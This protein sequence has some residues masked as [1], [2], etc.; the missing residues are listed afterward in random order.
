V[1]LVGVDDDDEVTSVDVRR[2]DRLVLAPQKGGGGGGETAQ[3]NVLSVDDVPLAAW[4]C[5]YAR[6]VAFASSV[7]GPDKVTED[8]HDSLDR[9]AVTQAACLVAGHR[10]GGPV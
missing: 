6:F 10:P 8:D 3:D 2:V 9:T 7:N 1:H 4:G 5:T